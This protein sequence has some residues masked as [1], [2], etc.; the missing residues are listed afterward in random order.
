MK[1]IIEMEGQEVRIKN[2]EAPDDKPRKFAFHRSY[3]STDSSMGHPPITNEDVFKDIGKEVLEQIYGGFNA[4]IFAYGQTGSGKSFS[5]EGKVPHLEG[6]LQ[7]C[8]RDIFRKKEENSIKGE[9]TTIKVTYLEIYNE[10]LR[11]LL[12]PH[13]EKEV[14]VIQ[15]GTA[16]TVSNTEA[17]TMNSLDDVLNAFEEGKKVRVVGSTKMNNT[18]SRS[19]AI[20]TIH[21][22]D[23]QNAAKFNIVDLAGSERQGKTGASG[24]RLK[25]ANNI[26]ASLTNLGIV[27]EKLAHNCVSKKSDFVPY[28]NSVLTHMLSESLAGNSKTFM[29]AAIS[30]ADDNY[31]ESLG[32]LKFAQRASLISTQTK[33]NFSSKEA[34]TKELLG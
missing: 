28:R 22:N 18:S 1:S 19:H 12:N 16:I 3:Y 32:T 13:N 26:N 8:L 9:A 33:K 7:L 24:D 2:P 30:P 11:D 27:I 34:Y 31:E 17:V 15:M 10:K 5:I 14:R 29:V 6:L 23:K 20:F 4:T 25:E 21:Y